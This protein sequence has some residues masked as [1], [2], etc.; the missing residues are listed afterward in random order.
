MCFS[1]AIDDIPMKSI[2]LRLISALYL[3]MN[4]CLSITDQICCKIRIL[5]FWFH[6]NVRPT[7]VIIMNLYWPP[8][9]QDIITNHDF[10]CLVVFIKFLNPEYIGSIKDSWRYMLFSLLTSEW[11]WHCVYL[12]WPCLGLSII[13]RVKYFMSLQWSFR[14]NTW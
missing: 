2:L 1:L 9:F 8:I 4:V 14:I 13:F 3:I 11:M 10:G 7:C 6:L 12:V 5:P